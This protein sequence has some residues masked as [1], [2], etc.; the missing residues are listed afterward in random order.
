MPNVGPYVERA[1]GRRD[2]PQAQLR[3]RAEKEITVLAIDGKVRLQ[4]L[5]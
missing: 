4:L 1:V 2:F 3:Q 5:G